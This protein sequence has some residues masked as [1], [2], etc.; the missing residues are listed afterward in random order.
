MNWETLKTD[1]EADWRKL[2]TEVETE[3]PKV[4]AI[5]TEV[6]TFLTAWVGAGGGNVVQGVSDLAQALY[7]LFN[8]AAST[9]EAVDPVVSNSVTPT[10]LLTAA[11]A[12]SSAVP[13]MSAALKATVT[14]AD[15]V[16]ADIKT[17]IGGH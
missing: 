8:V 17:E 13:N 14:A 16:V 15:V 4:E 12:I 1:L 2:V 10:Q 9:V 7:G 11:S 3:A 6:M 5:L